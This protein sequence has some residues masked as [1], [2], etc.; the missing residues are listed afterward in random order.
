MSYFL[1]LLQH[2]SEVSDDVSFARFLA[3]GIIF[4]WIWDVSFRSII[5]IALKISL[6]SK[7][8]HLVISLP[9]QIGP[10]QKAKPLCFCVRHSS[11]IWCV[12]LPPAI[13][14]CGSFPRV[15]AVQNGDPHIVKLG[16]IH[17]TLYLLL[18]NG[19][20][21]HIILHQCNQL[22]VLRYHAAKSK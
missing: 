13:S 4:G 1:L 5:T 19:N 9:L 21:G 10:P 14:V 22:W 20:V 18:G 3:R 2:Y 12:F 8:F 6:W 17:F 16:G 7:T 11:W 15:P